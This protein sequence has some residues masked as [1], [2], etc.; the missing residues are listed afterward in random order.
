MKVERVSALRTGR[1]YPQEIFL[2]LISVRSWVDSSAKVRPKDYVIEK[3]QW[4]HREWNP[5][6]SSLQRSAS[7]N[8]TTAW[9]RQAV[10][11]IMCVYRDVAL[12]KIFMLFIRGNAM[13]GA[14]SINLLASELFF[15]F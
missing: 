12:T 13:S 9:P 6:P 14:P 7:T 8:C 4:H 1:L 10:V 5:R 15:K 11:L 3:F 2:E